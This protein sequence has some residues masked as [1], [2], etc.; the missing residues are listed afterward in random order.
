MLLIIWRIMMLHLE[1]IFTYE[2]KFMYT[3]YE[4]QVDV[5]KKIVYL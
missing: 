4:T 2:S 3:L 5:L 1:T